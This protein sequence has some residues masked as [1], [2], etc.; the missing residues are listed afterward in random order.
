MNL[1]IHRAIEY[2]GEL[3]DLL[4]DEIV[5]QTV[6]QT[7]TPRGKASKEALVCAQ[8]LTGKLQAL[9]VA[10]GVGERQMEF[11]GCTACDEI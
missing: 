8:V 10:P 4:N 2:L 9:M 11:G 1:P 3:A 5:E 7:L 6:D